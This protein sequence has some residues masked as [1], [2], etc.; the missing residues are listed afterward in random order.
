MGLVRCSH[1]N[2]GGQGNGNGKG[3]TPPAEWP[4]PDPGGTGGGPE[5]DRPDGEQ[6]GMRQQRA[7]RADAA[8]D[9]RILW[10]Q[11]RPA[12]RHD[13]GAAD[14]ADRKPHLRQGSL[15]R[16]GA[17]AAGGAAAGLRGE[18]GAEGPGGAAAGQAIQQPGRA[19]SAA[20]GGARQGGRGGDEGRFRRH[21]RA[22]QRLG[23]LYARLEHAQPPRPHRM[24]QRVLPEEPREP[25]CHYVAAGQPDRRPPPHRSQELAG[26]A[27]NHRQHLPHPHVS[28]LN[29]PGRR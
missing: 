1:R 19:V 23:Q 25:G 15:R 26:K 12:L 17:A 21:Q 4:G 27:G 18:A 16:G 5:R 28:I 20:G 7:G 3:N 2:Q 10:R 13:A 6:V 8:P 9:R 22:V 11:H 24:A 14:G 29:R